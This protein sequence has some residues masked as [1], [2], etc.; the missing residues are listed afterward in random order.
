MQS[1]PRMAEPAELAGAWRL[2]GPQ[3][4]CRIQLATDEVPLEA[5]SLAAP[6][7]GLTLE[8]GCDGV[9]TARGWRPLPMGLELDD[10]R[11]FTVMAFDRAEGEMLRSTDGDW[12]LVRVD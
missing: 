10:A 9:Q 2:S 7:L 3:S 6:M 4:S 1:S 8:D 11:G 12:S 5:G